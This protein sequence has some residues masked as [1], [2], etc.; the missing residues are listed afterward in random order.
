MFNMTEAE[1]AAW[2]NAL[3]TAINRDT[4]RSDALPVA[5]APAD[6]TEAAYDAIAQR[7]VAKLTEAAKGDAESDATSDAGEGDR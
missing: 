4:G 7:V 6:A 1:Q 2:A 5:P 3:A